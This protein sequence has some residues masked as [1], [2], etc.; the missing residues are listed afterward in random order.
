VAETPSGA[1]ER[2][3]GGRVL[4]IVTLTTAV[5]ALVAA[6]VG[7]LFDVRPELR[8]D[9]RD[10]IGGRISSFAV[11]PGVRYDDFLQRSSRDRTTYRRRRDAYLRAASAD[12]GRTTPTEARD[13]LSL[14]G[15]MHYV[16]TTVEGFK[17]RTVVLRWSLYSATTQRRIR[18][19]GYEAVEAADVKLDAPNDS[20]VAQVWTP[21]VFARSAIFARLELVTSEG[22]VL[23]IAD[24]KP[25]RDVQ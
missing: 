24:S 18:A 22:Y 4:G 3:H 25:Y 21:P 15:T 2:G 11:E 8:P 13:L 23:A 1:T 17:R 12:P 5:I 20:S 9:P 16:N 7:L 14:R 19:P 6:T 10:Q